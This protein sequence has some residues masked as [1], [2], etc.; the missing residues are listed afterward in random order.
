M[1]VVKWIWGYFSGMRG[2][3]ILFIRGELLIIIGYVDLDYVEVI[4]NEKLI[5]GFLF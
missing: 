2:Y 5:I 1:W 4:E 3:K